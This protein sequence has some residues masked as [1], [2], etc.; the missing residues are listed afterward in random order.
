MPYLFN[1]LYLVVLLLCSPFLVYKG[2]RTGKYRRGFAA[3]LLGRVTHPLLIPKEKRTGPLVWFHGVSVGEIHLLR[4]VVA[5]W[6]KRHPECHV[7]VSTT[8][9]TGYDEAVKVAKE[10][11]VKVP[12]V[13]L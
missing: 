6:R 12:G 1:I 3:K 2:L 8:T 4:Q 11:G 5:A 7:V 9:D 13:T 10:R